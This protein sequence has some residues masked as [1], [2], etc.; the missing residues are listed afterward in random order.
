MVSWLRGR[1]GADRDGARLEA[2]AEDSP[3]L[4]G[5]PPVLLLSRAAAAAAREIDRFIL[6]GI[7]AVVG[8]VVKSPSAA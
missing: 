4:E 8:V 5:P 7:F 1:D 6:W 2:E 3:S